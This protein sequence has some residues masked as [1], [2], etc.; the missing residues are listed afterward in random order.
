MAVALLLALSAALTADLS[1]TYFADGQAGW[2]I[3]DAL[4]RNAV[5]FVRRDASGTRATIGRLDKAAPRRPT[6]TTYELD[7]A[8][9]GAG[10][11]HYALSVAKRKVGNIHAF[12]P[13]AFDEA[14]VRTPPVTSVRLATEN[15]QCRWLA[16][17]RMV[18]I[19]ARRS[20][21]VRESV[22]GRLVYES[23][24]YATAPSEILNPDGVQRTTRPTQ[25]V[26]DGRETRGMEGT[27]FRFENGGFAYIAAVTGNRATLTVMRGKR[28]LQRE[29]LLG[30]TFA[31]R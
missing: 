30:F 22:P 15:Y 29:Y 6:F 16:N 17:T 31:P 4:D 2:F 20:F 14:A 5:L 28:L 7:R 24:D 25:R 12:N 26:S 19:A 8:D 1:T 10:Q 3:C 13:G 21:V 27:T 18:G 9:P 23:F 11:I